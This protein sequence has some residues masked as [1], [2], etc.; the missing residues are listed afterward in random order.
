MINLVQKAPK[1]VMRLHKEY[2]ASAGVLI[3]P[4]SMRDLSGYNGKWAMDNACFKDYNPSKIIKMLKRYR[5]VKGCLFMT[6]P[7]VVANHEETLL[8]F[9]AWLGTIQSFGY[10][11]AFALAERERLNQEKEQE[12]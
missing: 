8:L 12:G 10:P 3:A 2:P 6:A 1:D 9:R 4:H 5:G 11:V 7:D